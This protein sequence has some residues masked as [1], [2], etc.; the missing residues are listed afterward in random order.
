MSETLIAV[1][2]INWY[3]GKKFSQHF[4]IGHGIMYQIRLS[5]MDITPSRNPQFTISYD[6]VCEEAQIID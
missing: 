4:P 5:M 1:P 3:H 6:R 2:E